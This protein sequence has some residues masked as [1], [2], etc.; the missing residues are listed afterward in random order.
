[1]RIAILEY[2]AS[3][4]NEA[5]M[6]ALQHLLIAA[7]HSA[8]FT[9]RTLMDLGSDLPGL[10]RFVRKTSADAWIIG[11]GS[12]SVL[13]WFSRQPFPSFALFGR[14]EELP[15]AAT[16]PDIHSAMLTATRHLLALGHRRIVIVC[17]A[18]R[19]SPSPGRTERAVLEELSSHGIATGH[20]NLPDWEESPQGLQSMLSSLFRL[21][22]PSALIIEEAP[23]LFPVLQFLANRGLCAP[24]DISLLCSDASPS[25]SWAAPS[26]AHIRWNPNPVIRRVVQWAD[27]IS[28][29][30]SDLRHSLT[31][32]EFIPGG[33][34]GPPPP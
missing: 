10:H 29:G 19:R 27:R 4:R 7:G 16:G 12:R 31:P 33:T 5:Y 14:R 34:I 20:F 3:S 25:F 9:D 2:D 22:P 11:A 13:A 32:A 30:Q 28:S 15:L 23:L 21:T 6:V 24:R 8:F 26:I 18:E 1:M 17:R